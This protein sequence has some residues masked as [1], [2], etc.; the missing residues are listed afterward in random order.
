MKLV[1]VALINEEE[2]WELEL[3]EDYPVGFD[4]NEFKNIWSYAGKMRFA[5]EHLGKPIGRGTARVVYRVDKDKVL[6]L[7]KNKKGIAQN[8][9][10][11]QWY[12]ENYYD[13]IIAKVIDYD[14]KQHLWVEMEIA[15][16]A[17]K[18]DFKRLW[19]I[20]FTDLWGY[21]KKRYWENKGRQSM[22]HIDQET[23][24]ELDENDNVQ[25]LVSFMYDSN[26]SDGDLTKI[27]SWG[28]VNRSDGEY[29]VLIDFGLNEDVYSTYYGVK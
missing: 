20:D 22:F 14:E 23:V 28:L 3:T 25:H 29:V 4:I 6:K 11:G 8:E 2:L 15:I 1:D 27:N 17:K 21:L 19:G 7:A 24:E 13:D 16:R 26:S 12:G 18:S 10:E 9:A 5:E